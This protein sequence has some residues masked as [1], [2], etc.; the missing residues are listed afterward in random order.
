MRSFTRRNR[1]AQRYKLARC[2]RQLLLVNAKA[3]DHP[4]V[5]RIERRHNAHSNSCGVF[6]DVNGVMY[7]TDTNAGLY[8]LQYEG[9]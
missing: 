4:S 3:A 6:V 8:I 2:N 9:T 5:M 1:I 7:V